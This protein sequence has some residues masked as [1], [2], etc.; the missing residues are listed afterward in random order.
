MESLPF[1]PTE[2]NFTELDDGEAEDILILM[3]GTE[4]SQTL[5]NALAEPLINGEI[6]SVEVRS[7]EGREIME[8]LPDNVSLPAHVIKENGSYRVGN[9]SSLIKKHTEA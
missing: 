1:G 7:N 2:K 3:E 4:S 5:V 8:R 6:K 9:L